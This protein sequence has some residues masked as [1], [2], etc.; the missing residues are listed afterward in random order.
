MIEMA[1]MGIKMLIV[2]C[3]HIYEKV[4]EKDGC[5][6]ER[7]EAMGEKYNTTCKI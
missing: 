3:L 6:E 5:G 4:L 2:S 7:N 1:N